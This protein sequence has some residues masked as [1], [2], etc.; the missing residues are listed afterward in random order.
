MFFEEI[1][2]IINANPTNKFIYEHLDERNI[3]II[4]EMLEKLDANEFK[5]INPQASFTFDDL[6]IPYEKLI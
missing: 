1:A 4:L 5:E 3:D 2:K 6:P